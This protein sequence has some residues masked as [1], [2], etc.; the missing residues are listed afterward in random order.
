MGKFVGILNTD[1]QNICTC[2]QLFFCALFDATVSPVLKALANEETSQMFPGRLPARNICCGHKFC[3]WDTKNVSDF[4]Q[5]HFV[6]LTNVSQFAQPKRH[7]RQ[8]CVGNNV[9]SFT[10]G[11]MPRNEKRILVYTMFEI[12]VQIATT[13]S[14]P[15]LSV[16]LRDFINESAK[17]GGKKIGRAVV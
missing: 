7:H 3:I 8:Q 5:K 10:R 1:S 12:N 15:V 13:L 9:S 14:P 2:Q 17:V 16:F 6:S 11:F 4:V